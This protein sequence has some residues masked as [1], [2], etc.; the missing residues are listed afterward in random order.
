MADRYN[1][2]DEPR[3]LRAIVVDDSGVIKT[4]LVRIIQQSGCVVAALASNGAEAVEMY[5]KHLPDF[6]TMDIEMPGINGLDALKSIIEHDKGAVVIM[7][8]S[9]ANKANVIESIKGG[10]KNYIIKP[11][12]PETVKQAISRCFAG[13][14]LK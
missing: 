8:T 7:V 5:K 10:A 14:E 1:F 4:Q 3:Q 2:E 6:V 11:F 12:T 13:V 9:V